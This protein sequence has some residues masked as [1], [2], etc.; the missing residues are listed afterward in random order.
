MTVRPG[1][2][3][4]DEAG[5]ESQYFFKASFFSFL[6]KSIILSST[7]FLSMPLGHWLLTDCNSSSPS[8]ADLGSGRLAAA[9]CSSR[10]RS[11]SRPRQEAP[12]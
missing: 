10:L 9:R 8:F 12:A 3:G 2:Y 6:S 5:S 7:F 4:A 1:L 11:G